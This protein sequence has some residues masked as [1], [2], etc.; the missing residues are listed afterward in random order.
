MQLD[1]GNAHE[2]KTQGTGWFIGFS[3]WTMGSHAGLRHVPAGQPLTGLCVKFFD[4][5]SG[6]DS[7]SDK[8]VSE[9]R[10]MSMLVSSGARFE[11][12]FSLSPDFS[13]EVRQV[14]LQKEGDYVAWGA[15]LYHRWRC[16]TRSTILTVRWSPF[17]NAGG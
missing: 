10:T 16:E 6:H 8:P 3:P 9:G 5:P 12:V 11:I 7:G 1:I 14:L 4:H 13:G 2:V 17:D 15:G